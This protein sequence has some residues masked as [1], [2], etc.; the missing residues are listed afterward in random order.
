MLRRERFA[1]RFVSP[2]SATEGPEPRLRP[3]ERLRG[4]TLR[5]VRFARETASVLE[6]KQQTVRK[7]NVAVVAGLVESLERVARRSSAK[8]QTDSA[9]DQ[10][11]RL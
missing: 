3:E 6:F 11:V 10:D 8:P 4:I 5:F 1:I 2:H 9:D 7:L